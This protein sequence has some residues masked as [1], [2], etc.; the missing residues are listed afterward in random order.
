[1]SSEDTDNFENICSLND[2]SDTRHSSKSLVIPNKSPLKIKLKINKKTLEHSERNNSSVVTHIKPEKNDLNEKLNSTYLEELVEENE[3]IVAL[4]REREINNVNEGPKMKLRSTKDTEFEVELK[5][6]EICD[7]KKKTHDFCCD[8]NLKRSKRQR[9]LSKIIYQD[10]SDKIDGI[11]KKFQKKEE[12]VVNVPKKIDMTEDSICVNK[13]SFCWT[14]HKD[15]SVVKCDTCPRVFHLKC[16]SLSKDP[17]KNWICPECSLVL[18]AEKM[19]TRSEAMKSLSLDQL[20]TLLNFAIGR[21]KN[22]PE[23]QVFWKAVDPKEVPSY[24]KYITNPMDLNLLERNMKAKMYGSPQAFLADTKWLLHNSIIFNS[25]QSPLTST[26]RFLVK[27]CRQEMAEIENCPDCYLNAHT[28]EDWFTEVCRKP[29]ILIWARLKGFPFWPAKAMSTNLKTQQVDAR[30]FGAHDK[31]WV[32]VKECYL[33]SKG[34]PQ[35]FSKKRSDLDDAFL[36][37]ETYIKKI[38]Q[39]YGTFSYAPDKTPFVPELYDKQLQKIS[40]E[41]CKVSE[42]VENQ[43]SQKLEI[44]GNRN[45]INEEQVE[46][47]C[48][49]SQENLC[50]PTLEQSF[51]PETDSLNE[52]YSTASE[53]Q[54]GNEIIEKSEHVEEQEKEK[55]CENELVS[56]N[57][58]VPDNVDNQFPKSFVNLSCDQKQKIINEAKLL[59]TLDEITALEKQKVLNDL[60]LDASTV[61]IRQLAQE[62]REIL[63]ILSKK[64]QDFSEQLGEVDIKTESSEKYLKKENNDVTDNGENLNFITSKVGTIKVKNVNNLF[65][66]NSSSA[67]KNS[68]SQLLQIKDVRSLQNSKHNYEVNVKVE[69]SSF[70]DSIQP[71][72]L[73]LEPVN[74]N[75]IS[76]DTENSTAQKNLLRSLR[77]DEKTVNDDGNKNVLNSVSDVEMDHSEISGKN[78][79]K[80]LTIEPIKN[81]ENESEQQITRDNIVSQKNLTV[82]A[83]SHFLLTTSRSPVVSGQNNQPNLTFSQN[84]LGQLSLVHL[85][86]MTNGIQTNF[87]NLSNESVGFNNSS[88]GTLYASQGFNPN[89][90][91]NSGLGSVILTPSLGSNVQTSLSTVNS[92]TKGS[93][94]SSDSQKFSG[95][96]GDSSKSVLI[97]S[98]N[99]KFSPVIEVPGEEMTLSGEVGS[100]T[101]ELNKYSAKMADYM[102]T[103]IENLLRELS[104]QGSLEAKYKLL[105]LEMEKLQWKHQQEISELK[106]RSEKTLMELRNTLQM[107]KQK[108]LDEL[109]SHLES[110]YQKIISE[111]KR[112]QWCANCGKEALF[113]CCWNT[114]YCDYPC[115]QQHWPG[116]MSSCAQ[117]GNNNVSI[118]STTNPQMQ[119]SKRKNMRVI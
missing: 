117:L 84:N 64:C 55:I 67:K 25:T 85:S 22:V 74:L 114:S 91:S 118:G 38:R 19:S 54:S 15:G 99:N 13:E 53:C 35:I 42:S 86:N 32:P 65:E 2:E 104:N 36:E 7:R 61:D 81:I 75:V 20:C 16:V 102:K 101:A 52:K 116:H 108:S 24:D 46:E 90:P 17:S 92:G 40:S 45:K 56:N 44:C 50:L 33:Y 71:K 113:Y 11:N 51:S 28:K 73:K 115:Q 68:T 95:N 112:K 110:H 43:I 79:M 105:I 37:A 78:S 70:N 76:V 6:K 83:N 9:K 1:M 77:S 49:D 60:G 18:H 34:S 5:N 119:V 58:E 8:S 59:A 107:D 111:T 89:F 66:K 57:N 96:R 30:F 109:K 4:E 103:A 106:Q 26:A 88:T 10:N 31:A 98:Q 63:E 97:T 14:C 93:K 29:H 100:V 12:N 72:K 21:M 62:N 94:I 80:E 47:N 23:S 41:I 3:E 48:I 87:V 39:I 82:V 69:K 27:I